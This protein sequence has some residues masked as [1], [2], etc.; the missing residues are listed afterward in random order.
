MTT[1]PPT[2]DHDAQGRFVAGN[3]LGRRVAEMRQILIDALT[4]DAVRKIAD[5]LVER[6]QEGSVSAAKL[7]LSYALG[8]PPAAA[9][10][11]RANAR[12]DRAFPAG[13]NPAAR[14]AAA[15]AAPPVPQ[16]RKS[17]ASRKAMKRMLQDLRRG[18]APSPNGSIGNG[19]TE[20]AGGANGAPNGP[21]ETV[22]VS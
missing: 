10:D 17:P 21:A 12:S 18:K 7:L 16:G 8:K 5:A 15:P 1:V 11:D 19:S 22:R 13:M 9:E 6:A 3:P 20:P 2:A 14:Q 4:D